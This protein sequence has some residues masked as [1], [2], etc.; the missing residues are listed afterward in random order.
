TRRDY[1]IELG[2]GAVVDEIE[3]GVVGLSV[4][5]TAEIEFEVA[6]GSRQTVTVTVK[7]IK[8]KVLPPLDDELARAASEFD[9]FAELRA[10]SSS[11]TLRPTSLESR[12]PTMRSKRSSGSRRSRST[13]T[14]TNSSNACARRAAS[15]RCAKTSGFET[16]ST[17]SRTT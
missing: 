6:D 13:T 11:S 16:P 14:R 1:V 2:R 9:T 7:E 8:E 5:E 10:E 4:G 15:S 12:S 3:Q 17:G